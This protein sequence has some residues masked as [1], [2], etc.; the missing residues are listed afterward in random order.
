MTIL[1]D[2]YIVGNQ[3]DFAT[4][5][6]VGDDGQMCRVVLVPRF[7][8]SGTIVLVNMA[9]LTVKTMQFDIETLQNIDTFL[10]KL[11]SVHNGRSCGDR[12]RRRSVYG[13]YEI[14][15]QDKDGG[16]KSN[17]EETMQCDKMYI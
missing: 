2:V 7:I 3:P 15:A 9:D 10:N 16:Q 1:P 14:R 8:D 4:K 11:L 12:T 5:L 6:V 13:S 17:T